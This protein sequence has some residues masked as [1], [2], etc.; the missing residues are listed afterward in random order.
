MW[1]NVYVWNAQVDRHT[2]SDLGQLI[3]KSAIESSPGTVSPLNVICTRCVPVSCGVKLAMKFCPPKDLTEL[4]TRPPFTKISKLPD[5]AR[6][7][8]TTSTRTKK[9]NFFLHTSLTSFNSRLNS[10]GRPTT[11]SG[12][13]AT[14][15]DRAPVNPPAPPVMVLSTATG[16]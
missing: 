14:T 11:P 13:S 10:T 8:S 7:P 1:W 5:P 12:I 9:L 4:V 2:R 3:N 15:I 6:D 16:L